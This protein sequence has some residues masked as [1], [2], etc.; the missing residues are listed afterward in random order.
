[1]CARGRPRCPGVQA[2]SSVATSVGRKAYRSPG[3]RRVFFNQIMYANPFVFATKIEFV[4][5]LPS[6]RKGVEKNENSTSR[7]FI[8]HGVDDVVRQSPAVASIFAP[9]AQPTKG[10]V[11]ARRLAG[12]PYPCTRPARVMIW[13][14]WPFC[15][16]HT[17]TNASRSPLSFIPGYPH[18]ARPM[19][20]S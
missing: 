5:L 8:L 3:W 7:V 19:T 9:P 16:G 12:S 17:A 15:G 1:M 10:A 18:R 6:R 14:I 11:A 2:H 20:E 13:D 4:T